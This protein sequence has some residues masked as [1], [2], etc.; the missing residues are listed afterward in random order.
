[1]IGR[2]SFENIKTSIKLPNSTDDGITEEVLM[3]MLFP[4]PLF[5]AIDNSAWIGKPK[6]Q[7]TVSSSPSREPRQTMG[8][9]KCLVF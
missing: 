3:I 6:A 9:Q 2:T 5:A 7:A 4:A 1:M 8:E